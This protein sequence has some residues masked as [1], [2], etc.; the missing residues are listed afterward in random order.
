MSQHES[1]HL[2]FSDQL[3]SMQTLPEDDRLHPPGGGERG[4][5]GG[6][7]LHGPL[8]VTLHRV[9]SLSSNEKKNYQR[10]PK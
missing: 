6:Q 7:L 8:Q 4:E 2:S 9:T 1:V 5:R 3:L 10:G